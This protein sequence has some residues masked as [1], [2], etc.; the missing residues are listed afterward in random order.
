IQ[1]RLDKFH[2]QTNLSLRKMDGLLL[3]YLATLQIN[4]KNSDQE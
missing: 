2:E 3:A 1:Y 4:T